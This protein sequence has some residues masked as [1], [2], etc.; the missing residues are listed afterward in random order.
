M[1]YTTTSHISVQPDL[2]ANMQI[3]VALRPAEAAN[4]LGV[5]P[6]TLQTWTRRGII[7]SMKID[8]VVLYSVDA[9]R[10]WLAS[11]ATA[12]RM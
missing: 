9:L 7:P 4:A 12:S 11:A 2:P 5:S 1:T 3:R 6:R 8:G 10:E